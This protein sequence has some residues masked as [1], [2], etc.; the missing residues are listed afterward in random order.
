VHVI[1]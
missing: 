1:H